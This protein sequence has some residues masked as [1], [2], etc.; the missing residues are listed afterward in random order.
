[1]PVEIKSAKELELMR[2]AGR[3]VAEILKD[4]SEHVRP[5]VTTGELNE[6]AQAI[7]AKYGATSPFKGYPNARP[8]DPPFPGEIC[9]SL[10]DEIVH[11]IPKLKRAL[12]EGEL[13]KVDCGAEF[14][15]YIG[16]AAWTFAVG[17]VSPEARRLMA[18]TESA[19]FK[20]I[21]QAKAGNHLWDVIRAI[22]TEV[23]SNG[24]TLVREYQGHGVGR[25]MHEEP[26]IP[27][28]LDEEYHRRPANL[29]LRPGLT[30]AIEPMVVTGTWRTRQMPDKWTVATRDHGL[31]AHYEHTIAVT[32]NGP[33]ILTLWT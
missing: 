12:K 1:M 9:T 24:F 7:L 26:S 17:T 21:A 4:I 23:E 16:D 15:G 13:L 10:N 3:I 8:S 11:G 6:R 30:V 20:G 25:D 5:G 27:N 29:L 19:L 31:A 33:E 28:F 2:A 18:V 32:E 14:G 22:Q